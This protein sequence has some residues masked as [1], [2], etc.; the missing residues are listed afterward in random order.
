MEVSITYKGK[1]DRQVKVKANELQGLRMVSDSFDADW[2]PGE[3]PRG[4]MIF[5]DTPSPVPPMPPDWKKQ[6]AAADTAEKKLTVLGKL[7]KLE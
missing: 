5:T 1:A 4:V 3:E 7:L 6:W 2:K